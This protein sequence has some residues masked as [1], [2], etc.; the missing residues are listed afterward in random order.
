[1]TFFGFNGQMDAFI[2][3]VKRFWAVGVGMFIFVTWIAAQTHT[4]IHQA[5]IE[6]KLDDQST[7]TV[8]NTVLLK[9]IQTYQKDSLVSNSDMNFLLGQSRARDR[10][11]DNRLRKIE[12]RPIQEG[13]GRWEYYPAFGPVPEKYALWFDPAIPVSWLKSKADGH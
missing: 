11:F 9:N 3:T 13:I 10:N 4:T 5:V 8:E 6:K 12:H 1:M 7:V 2:A